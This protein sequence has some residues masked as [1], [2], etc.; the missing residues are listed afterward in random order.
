MPRNLAHVSSERREKERKKKKTSGTER[1]CS[2]WLS[3]VNPHR[4]KAE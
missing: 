1:N 4:G 2:V 3:N